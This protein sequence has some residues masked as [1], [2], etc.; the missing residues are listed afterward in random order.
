ML[1]GGN[2][3]G[4]FHEATI[5]ENVPHDATMY[6]QEVFGP[7]AVIEPFD[8]FDEAIAIVNDSEYGLQAG[9]FTR[10][11]HKAFRAYDRIETGGVVI[12]DIP[13]MR[14][15]S[16]P[17]GGVKNS[18]RGARGDPLRDGGHDGDQ[19]DGDEPHRGVSVRRDR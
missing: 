18:G 3:D 13:S 9:V 2:R 17:Y 7:A 4:V 15:D 14:V 5:L 19:A 11:M 10:D 8:D 16:M 1:T 12:N 6:R